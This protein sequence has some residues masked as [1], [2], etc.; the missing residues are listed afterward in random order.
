MQTLKT[1]QDTVRDLIRASSFFEGITVESNLGDK[2]SVIEAA[3]ADKGIAVEVLQVIDAKS[4]QST[5]A[6]VILVVRLVVRIKLN[7]EQCANTSAGGANLN[8]YDAVHEA[9]KAVFGFVR[10]DG[11]RPFESDPED[12]ITSFRDDKGLL[13]YDLMFRKQVV[14]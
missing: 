7:A 9:V 13:C 11:E 4:P 14:I 12:F 6:A 5:K 3:L 10:S 8:V 1:I 2:D